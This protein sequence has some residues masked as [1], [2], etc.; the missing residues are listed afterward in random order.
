MLRLGS[1][2]RNRKNK[3]Q[4]P[5]FHF[6]HLYLHSWYLRQVARIYMYGFTSFLYCDSKEQIVTQDLL[7]DWLDFSSQYIH[8]FLRLSSPLK[9]RVAEHVVNL[10]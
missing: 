8:D 3:R 7:P 2:Y 10:A 5:W 9:S 6:K 1:I 4:T